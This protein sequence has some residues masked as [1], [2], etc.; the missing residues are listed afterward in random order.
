MRISHA[1]FKG[2]FAFTNLHLFFLLGKNRMQRTRWGCFSRPRW[3]RPAPRTCMCGPPQSPLSSATVW[4]WVVLFLPTGFWH[5]WWSSQ[6]MLNIYSH[7]PFPLLSHANYCPQE[8][9]AS[10]PARVFEGH[11]GKINC[12]KISM[13]HMFTSGSDGTVRR[14]NLAK[15]ACTH[16][17]SCFFL[18]LSLHV[19]SP[20]S[21]RM[22]DLCT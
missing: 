15:Y 7:L 8:K 11:S 2:F 21:S 16:A 9:N 13:Y 3:K 10:R 4:R 5:M 1:S 6:S 18:L 17:R 19:W 20:P 22:I 12:V 14:W